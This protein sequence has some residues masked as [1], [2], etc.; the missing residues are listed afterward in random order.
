MVMTSG[1]V[2]DQIVYIGTVLS[3]NEPDSK[4]VFQYDSLKKLQI[5]AN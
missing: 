5:F 4:T 3:E 2:S 1:N